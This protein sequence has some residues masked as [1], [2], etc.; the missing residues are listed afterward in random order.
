MSTPRTKFAQPDETMLFR[1]HLKNVMKY[2]N[3]ALPTFTG[4]FTTTLLEE[5]CWEIEVYIP[6]RTFAPTMEPIEFFL[7]APTWS[8]GRSMATHITFGSICEEYNKDLEDT[9]YRIFG[10][11]DHQW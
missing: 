2:L 1:R 5:K 6:G 10:R 8:L 7:D 4:T 9:I 3:I 11:R